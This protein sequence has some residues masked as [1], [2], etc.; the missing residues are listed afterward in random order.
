MCVDL[1]GCPIFRDPAGC[2]C[3]AWSAVRIEK[4]AIKKNR[5]ADLD[6]RRGISRL[7]GRRVQTRSTDSCR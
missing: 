2:P 4:E 1:F 7:A 6:S 5:G 3:W